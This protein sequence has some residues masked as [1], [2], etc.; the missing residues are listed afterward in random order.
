VRGTHKIYIVCS[1]FIHNER[2]MSYD[3]RGLIRVKGLGSYL[4]NEVKGPCRSHGMK[5]LSFCH[6]FLVNL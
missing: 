5:V 4:E 3:S 1:A 2:G 6:H